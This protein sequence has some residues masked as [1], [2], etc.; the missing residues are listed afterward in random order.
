METEKKKRG[1]PP[2]SMIYETSGMTYDGAINYVLDKEVKAELDKCLADKD[3]S[4]LTDDE[5]KYLETQRSNR[6][7]TLNIRFTESDLQDIEEKCKQFG[8]KS[9]STYVRDCVKA[10]VDLPVD[11]ANF[12]ET[13]RQMKRIGNNI[14]QIA[15]RLNSTGNFYAEDMIEIKKGVS[16][17]WR[18]LLSIQS[19]QQSAQR[20]LTSLTEI[21]P[22]TVYM[23]ALMLAEPTAEVLPRT[24]KPSDSEEQ[25]ERIYSDTT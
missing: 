5:R 22:S 3:E 9:K 7:K 19:E 10:R 25:G 12:A 24:S 23:S 8:Y 2:K 18:L 15:V 1:R 14:N 11:R 16:E 13:N 4:Q 21:R 6:T 17:L 20:S